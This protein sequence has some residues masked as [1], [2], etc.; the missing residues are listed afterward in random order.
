MKHTLF[1]FLRSWILCS[2][3]V[4]VPSCWATVIGPGGSTPVSGTTVAARPEL[5]GV[6]LQ[7]SIVNWSDSLNT[8]FGTLQ[9]RVV[10]ENSTGTLD[11]Y[12][13][14]FNNP[15]SANFVSAG[16]FEDYAAFSTDVDYRLDGLGD[17]GPIEVKR[18]GVGGSSV[19]FVFDSAEPN[20]VA[21]G[22][23]SLFLLIKTDARNYTT[24]QGDLIIGP[25]LAGAPSGD[26]SNLFTVWAP[27][28]PYSCVPEPGA[29]AMI[30]LGFAFLGVA[31]RRV[32]S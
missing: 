6:V 5:A 7:D 25:D 32:R 26:L 31:R 27:G 9:T 2:V 28:S 15:Q 30:A 11:F 29:Y 4:P 22:Q 16:R 24:S 10:Q 14:I 12:F 20:G 23:S 1:S 3:V 18:V 19:N 17:V 8:T 13:R 21:P